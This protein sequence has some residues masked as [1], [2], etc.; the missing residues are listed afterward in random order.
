MS[1]R[2]PSQC[3]ARK[4]PEL[5]KAYTPGKSDQDLHARLARV[6][7]VI[8]VAL[9]QYWKDGIG[10]I[11]E[12]NGGSE[13][14][15]SHS[16]SG[17][18]DRASQPDEED[19]GVFES[20]RWYGT[21][22]SGIVAAPAMLEKV[23]RILDTRYGS[24]TD[25]PSLVSGQLQNMVES[26]SA[27]PEQ[28]HGHSHTLSIDQLPQDIFQAESKALLAPTESTPA[29]NLKRLVQECGVSPHKISELLHELP[30]RPMT[31]KLVDLYFTHMCAVI[32]HR[33]EIFLTYRSS[34]S[35]WTRYPVS[36]RNFRVGYNSIYSEG[37]AINPNEFRFL[38]LL[39]VILAISVRLAP[40]HVAGDER[41]RKLTSSRYYWCC[42]SF[43]LRNLRNV[44][45]QLSWP[46][47]PGG[48]Y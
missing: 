46:L 34:Y 28:E 11:P 1:F 24:E 12:A 3:I 7:Q 41:T 29:D 14:H 35:N 2:R 6:E 23:R 4:V 8:A 31:D 42:E 16:P 20:G 39:F 30:P 13:R 10:P 27:A 9:P 40:E 43:S 19:V 48:H 15:R 25:H 47:Q 21:S 5:C 36:E 32:L 17:E 22:A 44:E 45:A 18:D 33:C 26:P 38:P 37:A